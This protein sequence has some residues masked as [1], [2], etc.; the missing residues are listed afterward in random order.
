MEPTRLQLSVFKQTLKLVSDEYG[1]TFCDSIAE[2]RHAEELEH[3][4]LGLSVATYSDI[5]PL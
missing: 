1:I 3:S 5:R 4:S 2:I